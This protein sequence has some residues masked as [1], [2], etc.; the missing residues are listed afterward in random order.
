MIM[1]LAKRIFSVYQNHSN[2]GEIAICELVLCIVLGLEVY[3]KLACFIFTSR[4]SLSYENMLE[5]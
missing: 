4:F 3:C 2:Y 1:I 5:R